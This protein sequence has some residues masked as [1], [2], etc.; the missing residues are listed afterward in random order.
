MKVLIIGMAASVA[1]W[2]GA[3]EAQAVLQESRIAAP[4]RIAEPMRLAPP[5]AP[6]PAAGAEWS[7]FEFV[8]TG[9]LENVQRGPVGMSYPPVYSTQLTFT[10]EQVIRGSLKVGEKITLAHS[11]RQANPP[12]YPEGKSCLVGAVT[13]DHGHRGLARIEEADAATAE[14]V[15]AACKLPLG[16]TMADGTATSPWAVFGEAVWPKEAGKLGADTVCAGSGRP[17][18]RCGAGIELAVKPL[19]PKKDIKWVNP[20]GDGDYQ[21]TVTNTTDKPLK[22]PAL[23]TDGKEIQWAN[24]LAILCQGKA[25]PAPGCKTGLAKL[26]PVELQPGQSVTGTVN[27]FG[28]T[29]PEWPRGGYRISFQFCLGEKSVSH[30]FYYY[31]SHHDAIR[32]A[33]QKANPPPAPALKPGHIAWEEMVRIIKD[34]PLQSVCQTHDRTVDITTADGKHYKAVEPRID[35]IFKVVNESGHPPPPMATE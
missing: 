5:S 1:A 15:T 28:L 2:H 22:V 4:A 21:V 19:P 12:A 27:P 9:K 30:A 18:L 10:V 23:L 25:Y 20:D 34:N 24:S 31:T 17:A 16:W 8:F 32:D 14:A 11:A 29:G 13:G 26:E 3:A 33:L 35:L 7:A 6:K